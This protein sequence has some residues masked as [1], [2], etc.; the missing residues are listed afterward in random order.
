MRKSNSILWCVVVGTLM[1]LS[2]S[3]R[4][5]S[6]PCQKQAED[7][8][9]GKSAY[10]IALNAVPY[11]EAEARKFHGYWQTLVK[12][13]EICQASNVDPTKA[14]SDKD[15]VNDA[16]DK[17]PFEFGTI[18]NDGCLDTNSAQ[19]KPK[20][21]KKIASSNEK[22]GGSCPSGTKCADMSSLMDPKENWQCVNQSV[23]D[24]SSA[25]SPEAQ[26]PA[27]L[28]DSPPTS[29]SSG[30]LYLGFKIGAQLGLGGH[31]DLIGKNVRT[32]EDTTKLNTDLPIR[33]ELLAVLE[34]GN[35]TF[36]LGP[37]LVVGGLINNNLGQLS[38]GGQF[39]A[40]Y[41]I[42]GRHHVF[43]GFGMT[44]Q[45][46]TIKTQVVD[47]STGEVITVLD[48]RT[49]MM[50]PKMMDTSSSQL[51]MTG[52]AGYRVGFVNTRHWR[53]TFDIGLF[54]SKGPNNGQVPIPLSGGIGFGADI[55]PGGNP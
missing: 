29:S 5:E 51:I 20:K 54:F 24:P 53:G 12:A 42:K 19:T 30:G 10:E 40:A 31:T 47:P 37:Q 15:G 1:S 7:A 34:T 35:F 39:K 27:A 25:N 33:L 14:D 45:G 22:C 32:G 52:T 9:K 6:D 18:M 28:P 8:V 2:T 16:Y 26:H 41:H 48:P 46:T 23:L 49:G 44:G 4:A 50:V 11:N 43:I 55:G 36:E 38:P 3:V 21:A 13:L 17:C